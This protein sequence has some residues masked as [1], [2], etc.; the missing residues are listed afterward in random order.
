MKWFSR[1]GLFDI[2]GR[3]IYYLIVYQFINWKWFR[4]LV[5]LIK[6]GYSIVR[7]ILFGFIISD[8]CDELSLIWNY[9][10]IS[11]QGSYEI[12]IFINVLFF[13][14]FIWLI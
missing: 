2:L 10:L 6:D 14:F 12:L 8:Q 9:G 7:D 1:P 11:Y 4:S 5:D 13:H 3:I